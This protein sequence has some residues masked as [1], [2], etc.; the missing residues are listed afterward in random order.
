MK[1]I[2]MFTVDTTAAARSRRHVSYRGRNRKRTDYLIKMPAPWCAAALVEW[3]GSLDVIQV[4]IITYAVNSTQKGPRPL[5][6]SPRPLFLSPLPVAGLA[7]TK[8][9]SLWRGDY[10]NW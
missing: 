1:G 7:L 9:I 6:L 2:R 4:Q 8:K 10:C 5:F 3:N